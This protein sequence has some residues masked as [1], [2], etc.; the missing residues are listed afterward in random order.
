M[1]PVIPVLIRVA[2]VASLALVGC[3]GSSLSSEDNGLTDAELRAE[4][5]RSSEFQKQLLADGALSY[6]EYETAVLA[7]VRCL[8][9]RG[10]PIVTPP[11][12]APGN[13]I[14]FEF[15]G[16]TEFAG[17]TSVKENE[18][19]RQAYE[20]CYQEH[21]NVVDLAWSRQNQADEETLSLARAALRQCLSAAGIAVPDDARGK[22]FQPFYKFEAYP[23]CQ[24]QVSEEFDISGFGG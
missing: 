2:C 19:A 3:R 15:G 11:H 14:A 24:Q 10:I 7:T 17:A 5:D 4:V 6:S 8:A 22:D 21:Q 20:D 18:A 13:V 1:R 9:D 23:A 12:P 16:S